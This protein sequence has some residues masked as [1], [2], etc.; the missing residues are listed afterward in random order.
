MP[1]DAKAWR[2]WMW[3]SRCRPRLWSLVEMAFFGV[4]F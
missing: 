1:L 3:T 4:L 2:S